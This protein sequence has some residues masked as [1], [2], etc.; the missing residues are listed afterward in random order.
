[1]KKVNIF[2]AF[3]I[4]LPKIVKT[5][6]L[7]FILWQITAIIQGVFYGVL[8]PATQLFFDKA[9]GFV[10]NKTT[11][12][13]VLMALGVLGFVQVGRQIINGIVQFII[14]MY[15]KK[16]DKVLSVELH[17]KIQR[18]PS[19]SFENTK[20]LDEINNAKQ[21]KADAINFTGCILNTF[22]FYIP[23]FL[24]MA[25]YLYKVKPILIV[26]LLLTFAPISI[27][28]ILKMKI[29]SKVE[30][31]SAPLRREVDYYENCIVGKEYFKETRILG[32][33][34]FFRELYTYT[35][36]LINKI[37]F[38]A[39]VKADLAQLA[40]QMLSLTGLVIILV[41]LFNSLISGSISPGAFSAIFTAVDRMFSLMKEWIYY[42]LG[43]VARDFGKVKYYISILNVMERKG[44]DCDIPENADITLENVSFA[45]PDANVKALDNISLNIK[46]GETVALVGKNGSGKSTLI[47]LILGLYEPTKGTVYHGDFDTKKVSYKS[48]FS[49]FSAVFQKYQ[50]YQISF[51]E[52]VG[53][54]NLNLIATDEN[55]DMICDKIDFNA[56]CLPLT[57]GYNTILSREFDGIDV[58]GGQ[59]QRIAIARSLFRKH[60]V[61]ILDEPTAA[62]DPIEET[63][64]YKRFAEISRNKTSIIVTHRLGSARIAD[65]IIVLCDGKLVEEGTHEDLIEKKGEYYCL[66]Q[67]QEQWYK[68]ENK[69]VQLRKVKG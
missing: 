25:I 54:S 52:N 58:S 35:L 16:A 34:G 63:N 36:K 12:S 20:T 67:S 62:I 10:T 29:F 3:K 2:K 14:T 68:D 17:E 7:I 6:P 61:I 40:M 9:T 48:L 33:T 28:Q 44:E 69:Q 11:L 37:R 19:I 64:I 65:R 21:G 13:G 57:D 45:Y 38:K 53:I 50:R 27:T 8:A 41:I 60:G 59:W 15:S 31:T 43:T 51:R 55:I 24:I 4:M 1:M 32:A 26:S 46:H 18:L 30:D 66:Y 56:R 42:S 39:I 5:S 49:R 47:R 23:F 22:N